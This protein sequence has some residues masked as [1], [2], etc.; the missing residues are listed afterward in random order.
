MQAASPPPPS[1]ETGVYR[2]FKG[3]QY[4]VI[5]VAPLVDS[6]EWFVVYRPL[7][8][9]RKLVLRPYAE[10]TGTVH[11]DGRDQPRFQL[12]RTPAGSG[13]LRK[14]LFNLLE[15][16]RLVGFFR[17]RDRPQSDQHENDRGSPEDVVPRAV[18]R[19]E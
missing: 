6:R 3:R 16:K 19:F 2:H 1:I 14:M 15:G 10:F 9:D 8:G 7:Y 11:R 12:I 5:G 17:K 4:E 18:R 13:Q